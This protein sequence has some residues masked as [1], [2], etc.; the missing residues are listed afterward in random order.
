MDR[1]RAAVAERGHRA[2]AAEVI[3]AAVARVQVA[4]RK[5]RAADRVARK[6]RAV[7]RVAR[8]VIARAHKPVIVAEPVRMA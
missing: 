6:D 1:I 7:V 4:E 8:L 5:D 3:R 2:A